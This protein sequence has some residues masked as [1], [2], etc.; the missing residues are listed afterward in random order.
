MSLSYTVGLALCL[1]Q[2]S[3]Y[4]DIAHDDLGGNALPWIRARPHIGVCVSYTHLASGSLPLTRHHHHH[5]GRGLLHSL[6]HGSPK[7]PRRCQRTGAR[8]CVGSL[9]CRRRRGGRQPGAVS[10]A[11]RLRRPACSGL[12]RSI[13]SCAQRMHACM[14]H[15]A[16]L[17]ANAVQCMQQEGKVSIHVHGAWAIRPCCIPT[18]PS[19]CP[20]MG[21]A[22]WASGN[23]CVLQLVDK[24]TAM[25]SCK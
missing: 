21:V 20:G 12:P 22:H 6:V 5:L 9:S 25:Q 24:W 18:Y 8:V 3:W 10:A 14:L 15:G 13:G 16:A 11:A 19:A 7:R 2:K 17:H 1:P 23:R 4:A